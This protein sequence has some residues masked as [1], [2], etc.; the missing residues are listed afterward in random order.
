[1]L[2]CPTSGCETVLESAYSSLFGVPLSLFGMLT[3]GAVSALAASASIQ[4]E[5][6]G[7]GFRGG[8]GTDL[9]L[10]SGVTLLSTCRYEHG[11]CMMI[12]RDRV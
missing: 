2:V 5:R 4:Q 3:Y 7:T 10:L 8:R 11:S 1:M 6:E 9:L 12:L